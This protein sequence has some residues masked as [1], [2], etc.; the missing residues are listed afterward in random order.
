MI[1]VVAAYLTK[2]KTFLITKRAHGELKH[3]N[4]YDFALLNKNY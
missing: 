1:N 4:N 2:D 3:S